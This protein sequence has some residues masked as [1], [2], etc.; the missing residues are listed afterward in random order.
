MPLSEKEFHDAALIAI[1]AGVAADTMDD[2]SWYTVDIAR[3]AKNA[4]DDL[5]KARNGTLEEE[6]PES[7]VPAPTDTI[8]SVIG[9]L[10]VFACIAYTVYDL[11]NRF[12]IPHLYP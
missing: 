5:V 3:F 12:V 4:A 8:Q 7:S 9:N 1:A 2:D 6:P 11:F 10:V